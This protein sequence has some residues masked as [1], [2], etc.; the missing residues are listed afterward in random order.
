MNLSGFFLHVI[1]KNDEVA[2]S[3]KSTGGKNKHQHTI[4][5]A[6]ISCIPKME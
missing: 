1:K 2:H 6:G 4:G 3:N 5:Y